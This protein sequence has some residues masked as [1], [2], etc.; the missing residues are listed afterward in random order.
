VRDFHESMDAEDAGEPLWIPQALPSV[1][2]LTKLPDELE[3]PNLQLAFAGLGATIAAEG[4]DHLVSIR[5]WLTRVHWHGQVSEPYAAIL[6]LDKLFE[7]RVGAA[8]RLWRALLG[9]D[10]GP[11]PAALTPERHERLV[12]AVRALDG[13]TMGATHM[14]IAAVLFEAGDIPSRDWIAHP[15]RDKTGRLV[16][17]G[18]SMMNGGYRQLLLYPYRRRVS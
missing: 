11:D 4:A 13:R 2:T 6:P 17:L 14:Q 3:S 10:P 8:L 1:T 5:S 12:L 18:L 16:R 15:L 9:R 7:I